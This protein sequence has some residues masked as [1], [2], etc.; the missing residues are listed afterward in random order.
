MDVAI[1]HNRT[2]DGVMI[3]HAC[4]H[5]KLLGDFD[6]RHIGLDRLELTTQVG[7]SIR[8]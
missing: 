3:R 4:Q 8:L 6:A 7:G 5:G 2:D 1:V